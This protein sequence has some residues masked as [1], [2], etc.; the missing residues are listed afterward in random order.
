MPKDQNQAEI[1]QPLW[2]T[3]E[4]QDA[5][6]QYLPSFYNAPDSA[7]LFD[8]LLAETEWRQEKI[9]LFGKTHDVPRLSCWMADQGLD[10]SYSNM[11]MQATPWT[12]LMRRVNDRLSLVTGRDFN[13]VLI[14]CYRDGRDS[15]G[16]HSDDEP[17]LGEQPLIASVSLGSARD[18]LLRRRHDHTSKFRISLQPGS[19]LLM[20]GHTQKYWQHSI[21]KRAHA[22]ARINLTFRNII[23]QQKT[24]E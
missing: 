2:Q 17:E 22:D 10:Y 5:E 15:N 11:T 3:I 12:A 9:M 14:N 18:F 16:W 24:N 19:L 1:I 4:L 7:A 20:G 23:R 8:R 6:I 21:P 13:S